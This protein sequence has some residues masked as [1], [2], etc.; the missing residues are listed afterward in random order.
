[1]FMYHLPGH[2]SGVRRL[3]RVAYNVLRFAQ[4]M[5]DDRLGVPYKLRLQCKLSAFSNKSVQVQM[6]EDLPHF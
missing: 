6:A 2:G 1:M 5:V 4:T 3:S